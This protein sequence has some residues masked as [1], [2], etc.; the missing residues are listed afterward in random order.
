[1]RSRASRVGRSG[2]RSS[3][4]DGEFFVAT[5]ASVCLGSGGRKGKEVRQ[6]C[7]R[8]IRINL[9]CAHLSN[10]A[11]KSNPGEGGARTTRVSSKAN[12]REQDKEK[13]TCRVCSL[14]VRA[15]PFGRALQ[16]AVPRSL[17]GARAS[18][19]SF[20]RS[21]SRPVRLKMGNI[22]VR[23][24][25]EAGAKA[26]ETTKRRRRN[27]RGLSAAVRSPPGLSPPPMWP[28]RPSHPL[29]YRRRIHRGQLLNRE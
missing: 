1:M 27:L 4:V 17:A 26:V 28:P 15:L 11:T 21:S 25:E 18:P 14:L 9:L 10:T 6:S 2:G 7:G 8:L 16:S 12:K 13:R 20:H 5:P 29:F 23:L 19:R 3:V 22:L 24:W